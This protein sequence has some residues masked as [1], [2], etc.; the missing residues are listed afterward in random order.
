MLVSGNAKIKLWRPWFI[1]RW[2]TSVMFRYYLAANKNKCS[3]PAHR[4]K[5][6]LFS[7]PSKEYKAN[8]L[9]MA[10]KLSSVMSNPIHT[11]VVLWR[12]LISEMELSEFKLLK[13]F[14]PMPFSKFNLTEVM[15]MRV[16]SFTMMTHCWFFTKALTVLWISQKLTLQSN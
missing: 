15:S 10:L 11:C 9:S 16:I 12:L 5:S 14:H 4:P 1:A 2:D 3:R 6:K 8:Q 7:P 13:V